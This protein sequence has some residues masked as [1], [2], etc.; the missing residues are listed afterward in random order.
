M[1]RFRILLAVTAALVALLSAPLLVRAAASQVVGP[2]APTIEADLISTDRPGI[3]DSSTVIDRGRLQLEIGYQADFGDDQG[4]KSRT[5]YVPALFRVGLGSG[6]E[7]RIETNTYVWEHTSDASGSVTTSGWPASSLGLKYRFVEATE[8]RRPSL[9]VIGRVF[10][11]S[12]SNGFGTTR[13]TSDARLVADVDLSAAW[14]LNPNVGLGR[15]EGGGT[16]FTAALIAVTLTYAPAPHLSPFVDVAWQSPID[17]NGPSSLL[18]DAG[19][20]YIVGRNI[21]L[22]VSAGYGV[23]GPAP[24]PFIS[25][26]VSLR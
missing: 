5:S 6:L 16:A 10:P 26:G 13:L 8:I 4:T 12:G 14:S 18:I 11:A 2:T 22:D 25:F 15:Y 17:I 20:G 24:K 21:Q 19:L 1:I 7:G 9:A 3:A 23:H